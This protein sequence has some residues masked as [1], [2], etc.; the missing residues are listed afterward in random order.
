MLHSERSSKTKPRSRSHTKQEAVL[1][2]LRA[3]G[4][5]DCCHH[6]SHGIAAAFGARLFRRHGTQ[7]PQAENWLEEGRRQ[8]SLPFSTHGR[9]RTFVWPGWAD[10]TFSAQC[11][12]PQDLNCS[13][14][15]NHGEERRSG[16]QSTDTPLALI[17]TDHFRISL[18]T[19]CLR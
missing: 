7:A 6:E 14:R 15:T 5:N 2:M 12:S 8:A 3:L 1:G 11:F 4:R 18:L 9:R 17:G 10:G 13:I 19:N 16:G